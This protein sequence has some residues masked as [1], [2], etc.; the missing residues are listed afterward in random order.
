[1]RKYLH[2]DATR[3]QPEKEKREKERETDRETER[4]R[5][6]REM[7]RWKGKRGKREKKGKK[8]KTNWKLYW[9]GLKKDKLDVLPHL[10][11]GGDAVFRE[12]LVVEIRDFPLAG[13]GAPADL[14]LVAGAANAKGPWNVG[15]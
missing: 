15:E 1:L 5:Q 11:V 13:K 9:T 4:E 14:P 10:L 8:K 7:G 3:T 2:A 12:L 6:E